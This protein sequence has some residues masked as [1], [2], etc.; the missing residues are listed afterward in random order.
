MQVLISI[1]SMIFVPDPYFNEPCFASSRNTAQGKAASREY[2]EGQ[3][4]NTMLYAILPALKSP[5]PA[6]ALAIR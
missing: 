4:L 3:Q 6:F 2:D 1:Q 5:C